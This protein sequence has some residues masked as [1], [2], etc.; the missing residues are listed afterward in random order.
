M[1]EVGR[2]LIEGHFPRELVGLGVGSRGQQQL[3][4]L[5]SHYGI[6]ACVLV[7]RKE[8]SEVELSGWT[9]QKQHT[10]TLRCSSALLVCHKE[11]K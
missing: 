1:Q 11:T 3:Q 2:G 7:S 10:S 5:G 4:P 6:S 9:A 8:R